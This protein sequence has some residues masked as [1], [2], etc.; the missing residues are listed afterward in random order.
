LK[1]SFVVFPALVLGM[2]ALA[3]AQ[4]TPPTKVALIHIQQA[5][6]TTKD[7]QK[8]QQDLQARF[9]PKRA[10]LEKKQADLAATQEQLRKGAATMS[11]DAKNKMAKDIENLTKTL[12]REGEDF[13]AEVQQEEGKLMNDLG[14]K[15]M[16][17]VGKYASQNN[18]AMVID[19]SN[20][21][22]VLWAD[23]SANITAECIKLYDQ[24]HAGTGAA[25][26]AP[27]GAPKPGASTPPASKP[28]TPAAPPTKKQ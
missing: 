17:V 19:I 16:E 9:G 18:F 3:H 2:A 4:G 23:P 1:K 25:P 27:A 11:D 20:Q 15:M 12:T 7:G 10:T 14:Q 28:S 22:T 6:V 13:D 5:I 21:Q 8:A 26:A 24:A